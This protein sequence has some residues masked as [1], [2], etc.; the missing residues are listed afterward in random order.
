MPYLIVCRSVPVL[1]DPESWSNSVC[2]IDMTG[3]RYPMKNRAKKPTGADMAH[4]LLHGLEFWDK[5]EG[6]TAYLR[7]PC[8]LPQLH[9]RLRPMRG[10]TQR[11]L[12]RGN[13]RSRF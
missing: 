11:K 4:F 3:F 8:Q 10:S 2:E 9:L 13:P 1:K 7:R 12:E 5:Q 6:V